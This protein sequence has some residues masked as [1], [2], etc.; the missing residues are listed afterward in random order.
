MVFGLDIGGERQHVGALAARLCFRG[1]DAARGSQTI[2]AWHL[3]IHQDQIIG[4]TGR[5][6]RQPGF[7]GRFPV[8]CNGW[9]VAEARQQ[10]TRQKCVDLIIL[11]DK[12]R[13]PLG[14]GRGRC[15]GLFGGN[16]SR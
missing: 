1:T 14:I 5:S 6:R 16:F 4:G 12:D 9:A 2:H 15:S 8:A 3:H 7:N 11:G 10:C 13:Q